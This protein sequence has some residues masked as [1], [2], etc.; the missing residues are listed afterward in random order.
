MKRYLVFKGRNY[1]PEGGMSDILTSC[2]SIDECRRKLEEDIVK[3]FE[4]E[5]KKNKLEKLD[6]I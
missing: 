5:K 1:Y 3:D 6:Y 2:D 4:P